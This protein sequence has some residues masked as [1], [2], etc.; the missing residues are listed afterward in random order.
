MKSL[1]IRGVYQKKTSGDY[2]SEMSLTF[3]VIKKMAE[4]SAGALWRKVLP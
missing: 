3:P 1:K 2:K 4:P